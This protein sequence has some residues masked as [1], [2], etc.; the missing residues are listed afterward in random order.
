MSL[1]I[2]FSLSS[3]DYVS[4]YLTGLFYTGTSAGQPCDWSHVINKLRSALEHYLHS[5]NSEISPRKVKKAGM[6]QR[7]V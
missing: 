1:L 2:A 3:C 6:I 4:R 7:E 5:F